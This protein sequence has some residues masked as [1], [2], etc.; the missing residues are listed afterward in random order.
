[1]GFIK[2]PDDLPA[3]GEPN[4]VPSFA[5]MALGANPAGM[6]YAAELLGFP[7]HLKQCHKEAATCHAKAQAESLQDTFMASNSVAGSSMDFS[8]SHEVESL[9][10]LPPENLCRVAL[11]LWTIV[12]MLLTFAI[13]L[14]SVIPSTI[15]PD[16]QEELFNLSRIVSQAVFHLP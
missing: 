14:E 11:E 6:E 4:L 9:F 7:A 2:D 15:S 10:I 1:M 8:P 3:A 16:D 5:A 12:H 13:W